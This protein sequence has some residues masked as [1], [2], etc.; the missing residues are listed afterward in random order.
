[1]AKLDER[2]SD[3]RP[4]PSFPATTAPSLDNLHEKS[5][6]ETK[7]VLSQKRYYQSGDMML[8]RFVFGSMNQDVHPLARLSRLN[9]Q[10]TL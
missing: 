3:P 9:G 2:A 4:G 5:L 8:F 1:M 10:T 7:T 6:Q